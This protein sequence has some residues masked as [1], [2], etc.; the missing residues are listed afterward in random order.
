ME[1]IAFVES[2]DVTKVFRERLDKESVV[3]KIGFNFGKFKE[4][5]KGER[6]MLLHLMLCV[7]VWD[8]VLVA[9]TVDIC[10]NVPVLAANST[11]QT[12]TSVSIET[13]VTTNV[14]CTVQITVPAGSSLK[15]DF[16][17]TVNIGFDPIDIFATDPS[18]TDSVLVKLP[19]DTRNGTIPYTYVFDGSVYITIEYDEL[20]ST[21]FVMTYQEVEFEEHIC[22]LPSLVY[23]DITVKEIVTPNFGN[24]QYF[25]NQECQVLIKSNT[26]GAREVKVEVE[27]YEMEC[28]FDSVT[29]SVDGVSL[30]LCHTSQRIFRGSSVNV[31]LSTDGS[32]AYTGMKLEYSIEFTDWTSWKSRDCYRDCSTKQRVVKDRRTRTC[33]QDSCT[34]E[35]TQERTRDCPTKC[36]DCLLG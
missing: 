4:M 17:S 35:T 31:T 10:D 14:T 13:N 33:L 6:N 34:G 11:P 30:N 23:A 16:I 8:L 27:S 28:P 2:K 25:N 19:E 36:G 5:R 22:T 1:G 18:T 21:T 26:T 12:L 29:I 3:I 24:G 7:P 15:L 9:G 20:E 32:V